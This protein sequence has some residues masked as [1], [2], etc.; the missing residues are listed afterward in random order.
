MF[1]IVTETQ[2][3]LDGNYDRVSCLKHVGTEGRQPANLAIDV[4]AANNRDL[5]TPEVE[6]VLLALFVLLRR[7]VA[8]VILLRH[9]DAMSVTSETEH[10]DQHESPRVRAHLNDP[11]GLRAARLARLGPYG[12]FSSGTCF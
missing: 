1:S 3:A 5:H 10:R 12:R 11:R 7:L 6:A 9:G 8:I 4:A 2:L